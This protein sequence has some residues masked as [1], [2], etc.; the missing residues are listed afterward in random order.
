MNPNM[1]E[2]RQRMLSL[3]DKTRRET[4]M[5]LSSLDPDRVIH[6]DEGAWRVRDII[7]HLGVWNGEAVN[8]LKAY[9]EGAEYYCIPTDA[10]YYDYN[11][12]AADERRAWSLNQVWAEYETAHDQLKQIVE[13][14]P[15]EKWD[16]DMV[17]PWNVR[18]SVE[19]LIKVMM[20]HEKADH[21]DLVVRATT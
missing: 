3:L 7:G 5:L 6:R 20:D 19:H 13:S 16:G 1:E 2:T 17:Y 18:G 21:C 9:A 11:G 15:D 4:H 10:Q 8:S 12:P 14:L